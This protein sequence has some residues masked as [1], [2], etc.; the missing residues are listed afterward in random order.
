[1]DKASKTEID[2][3]KGGS[4][5]ALDLLM[6]GLGLGEFLSN[7]TFNTSGV[8]EAKGILYVEGAWVFSSP[9]SFQKSSSVVS[10]PTP[11]INPPS[12]CPRSIATFKLFPTS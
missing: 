4:P 9:D 1:M 8:S 5:T 2:S 7:E 3:I 6:V 11:C 10:Q 12:I